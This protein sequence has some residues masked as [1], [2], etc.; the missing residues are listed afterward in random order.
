MHTYSI[1]EHNFHDCARFDEN[2]AINCT[3]V[4]NRMRNTNF[5]T[6]ARHTDLPHC[7]QRNN[8]LPCKARTKMNTPCKR[9]A[10]IARTQCTCD[11]L[12]RN[13]SKTRIRPNEACDV[14]HVLASADELADVCHIQILQM[15]RPLRGLPIMALPQQT[16][17]LH[18]NFQV[19]ATR[20]A[21]IP[22]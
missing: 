10:H 19:R 7:M 2:T 9:T 11:P 8:T 6:S 13:R 3:H 22:K 20:Y 1:N 21:S 5:V 16:M 17:L 18:Q 4:L 14:G 12:F 15:S